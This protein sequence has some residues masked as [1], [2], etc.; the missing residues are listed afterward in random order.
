LADTAAKVE[1]RTPPEISCPR[2]RE[3]LFPGANRFFGGSLDR[4]HFEC[5]QAKVRV[6]LHPDHFRRYQRISRSLSSLGIKPWHQAS[7]S[8]LGQHHA[9]SVSPGGDLVRRTFLVVSRNRKMRVI[10][11]E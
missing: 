6:I 9:A 3:Y 10:V 8:S 5:Q 2:P 7:A 1:N 4:T 11:A